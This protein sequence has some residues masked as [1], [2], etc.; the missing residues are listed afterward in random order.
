MARKRGLTIPPP[1]NAAEADTV[2][3]RIGW[4]RREQARIQLRLDERVAAAKAEA[5]AK[6]APLAEEEAAL[7]VSLEVWADANRAALTQGGRVK[8]VA[9][10]AGELGW[11]QRPPSVRLRD[12][13]AVLAALGR[14]GLERF[15]RRK[16]E[17]DKEAMLREPAVAATVPGV[18]IV[19]GAEQF[20][21]A[22]V[23]LPLADGRA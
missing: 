19:A 1:A 20:V 22:P 6:A 14:L 18:T 21:V 11:R 15:I 4:L 3:A 8:T 17:V 7:V 12:A 13:V 5:E 9:L 10:A 23:E 2:L 16:E